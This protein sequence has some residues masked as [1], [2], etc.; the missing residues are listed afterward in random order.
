MT[1][2][3]PS[4]PVNFSQ[5]PTI[6][7]QLTGNNPRTP[8]SRLVDQI[9]RIPRAHDLPSAINALNIM[10]NIILQLT[11]GEPQINNIGQDAGGGGLILKGQEFG[12]KY[13][14]GD[15]IL[16]Q[17]SYDRSEV[18]NPDDHDQRIPIKV[19]KT[20]GFHFV[21]ANSWLNYYT[22][23]GLGLD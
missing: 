22:P 9:N 5:F 19:L 4:C 7:A 12:Q 10:N 18:V 1:D 15:W 16:E 3:A 23:G 17:R 14:P 21:E 2:V 11:R 20:V 8:M 13:G 6:R